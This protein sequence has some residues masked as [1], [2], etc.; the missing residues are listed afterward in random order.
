MRKSKAKTLA[1]YQCRSTNDLCQLQRDNLNFK[2][3]WLLV[4]EGHVTIAEQVIGQNSTTMV[5][6]SKRAFESMARWYLTPQKVR[7]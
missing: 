6:I 7:K 1:P 3:C 2:R 5:R 4:N